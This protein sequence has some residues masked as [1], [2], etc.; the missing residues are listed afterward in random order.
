MTRLFALTGLGLIAMGASAQ[1]IYCYDDDNGRRVCS[2]SIPPPAARHDRDVLNKQGVVIGR[3]QGEITPE[4][5]RELDAQEQL[6]EQRVREAEERRQYGQMLLDSYTS[7]EDIEKMR[8]RMLEQID[9][10]I[11]VIEN[12]LESLNTKLADLTHR[13]QRFAPFN[14]HEDAPPLPENLAL[15]IERTESSIALFSERLEQNRQDQIETRENFERDIQFFRE[16]TG[17]DV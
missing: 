17:E 16:L 3:E 13:A 6:E 1:R 12:Y 14:D 11:A 5:Q 8:D 4:E 15:D 2:D 7:V 9:G 10:Q